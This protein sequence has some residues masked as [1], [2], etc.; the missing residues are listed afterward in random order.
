MTHDDL[1][2]YSQGH[3]V[4]VQM[5][6]ETKGKDYAPLDD[7]LHEF[8]TTAEAIGITPEQVWAV[9]FMKQVKAVL[10]YCKDGKLDS[11]GIDSRLVDVSAY[12]VLLRA[13]IYDKEDA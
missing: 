1:I 9:H 11:E 10:R 5:T 8:R 4:S 13:I 3:G 6:L 12:A 7:A 2:Q